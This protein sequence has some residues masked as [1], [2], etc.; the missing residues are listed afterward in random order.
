MQACYGREMHGNNYHN[1]KYIKYSKY[2][3]SI[4]GTKPRDLK[5]LQIPCAA[6]IHLDGPRRPIS[7]RVQNGAIIWSTTS[8]QLLCCQPL[9][10]TF[11][12]LGSNRVDNLHQSCHVS[13]L[14]LGENGVCVP[15]ISH[16][17][18]WLSPK[19]IMIIMMTMTRS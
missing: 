12:A 14:L 16:P 19:T 18:A 2:L 5:T 8:Y 13:L 11:W 10:H 9:K 15:D 1:I 4:F 17:Q 7:T 6:C 3:F